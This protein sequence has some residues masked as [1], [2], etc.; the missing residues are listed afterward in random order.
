MKLKVIRTKPIKDFPNY[1]ALDSGEIYSIKREKILIGGINNT[2]NGYRTVCLMKNG[3]QYTKSIHRLIAQTFVPN[4]ENKPEVN[5]I[6]G[7]TKNNHYTNLEWATRSENQQHAYDTGLQKPQF[8]EDNAMFGKFGKLHQNSKIVYQYALKGNFIKEWDSL[9]SINRELGFGIAHI[10]QC[11]NKKRNFSNGFIWT[12]IKGDIKPFDLKCVIC[13]KEII[14]SPKARNQ[15][16]CSTECSNKFHGNRYTPVEKFTRDCD[17]CTKEFEA[18]NSFQ[19][20]CST[21][22][23]GKV[24]RERQKRRESDLIQSRENIYKV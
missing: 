12:Y 11:C 22:C 15:K 23:R 19:T 2:G 24:N 8:G 16:Y 14:Y 1:L 7:D 18:K 4:P 6:N 3:I 5:H 17:L 13:G 21:Q 20:Y 9:M 10:S